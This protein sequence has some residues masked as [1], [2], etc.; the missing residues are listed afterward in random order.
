MSVF[1]LRDGGTA[2]EILESIAKYEV[3]YKFMHVCGTHQDTMVHFGLEELLK[4]VGVEIRQGPGCPVCVTTGTEIGAGI[5]LAEAGVAV[6]VFGDMLNVPTPIGSLDDARSRGADVRIVYSI[7]DA[8][9]MAGRE[10]KEFVF[11]AVG[12]ETTAPTTAVPLIRGVPENFSVYSCHRV[13]PPALEA[14]F[15]MGEVSVDGFIQP[16]H[17]SAITGTEMYEPFSQKYKMPQVV[18]GFEPLDILMA[19]HML[20]RQLADGRAEVENEYRRLVRKEG[21]P[22]A[23]AMMAKVFKEEDRAWRG[24]PVIPLS[25]LGLRDEY[26]AHDAKLVHEDLLKDLPSMDEEPKGC[27]CGEV[28]RGIIRS[29]EC[30]MFGRACEPNSPKGPCMVSREGSC[31]IAYR[32]G[33]LQSLK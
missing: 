1:K 5:A 10:D 12:F 26:S 22:K 15:Q 7:T 24:F 33:N 18:A 14:I 28:L 13:V 30:P 6:C 19:C 11:M 23:R 21:N 2:R 25:A 16:G 3:D 32:Y 29:E 31:N 8:V 17:V 9:E 27:R 4:D 20:V